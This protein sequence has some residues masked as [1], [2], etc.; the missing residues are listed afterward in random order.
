MEVEE[1]WVA[2]FPPWWA[3]WLVEQG[4]AKTRED[5]KH[6]LRLMRA[7]EDGDASQVSDFLAA[8]IHPDTQF[9]DGWGSLLQC[10][11]ERS[12]N[13]QIANL[14]IDAGADTSDR[15]ILYYAVTRPGFEQIAARLVD[16]G[17]N[18]N[19][20]ID[21]CS[22]LG[23]AALSG[24]L[25]MVELLLERGAKVD[26]GCA[27]TANN[28]DDVSRCTP[29]MLAAWQRHRSIVETLLKAGANINRQDSAGNTALDWATLKKSKRGEK[30]ARLLM[31]A[32]AAPG[33]GEDFGLVN[34]PDFHRAAK[35]PEFQ[36]ALKSL[37]RITGSKPR[38]IELEEETV[39]G[40]A[41]FLT[42]E[43]RAR[44]IVSEHQREMGGRGAFIFWSRD[45]TD[46]GGA[47]VVAVPTLDQLSAVAAIQT[48]GP[49]SGVAT[50]H[51][52]DWLKETQRDQPLRLHGLGP[53]FV[54]AYFT[55]ELRD[56]RELARR[57]ADLCPDGASTPA[58]L[59]SYAQHLASTRRLFLWWD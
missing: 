21:R 48:A 34:V 22:L 16:A 39:K 9:I 56:P 47:C 42:E 6:L 51:L 13:P 38:K 59:E 55:S 26:G 41:A 15:T 7:M 37:E 33:A 44:Q 53:D 25:R 12:A 54:E 46:R 31:E 45:V 4:S 28:K 3:D 27:I 17:G 24:S 2:G 1:E 49:N 11:I 18:P 32:G 58:E 36:Q 29:L 23:S 52:I 43:E 5:G 57:V 10:A 40:P 20:T 30:V 35:S 8:G 19:M 50:G 14:L